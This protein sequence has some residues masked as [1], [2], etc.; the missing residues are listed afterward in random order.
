MARRAYSLDT[1][2]A[3]INA[4]YP[5]R[6]KASDGWLGDAAHQAVASDHNPNAQGVVTA[7]DITH[8][9]QTG[10]DAHALAD[11]LRVNRHPNLKYI[12]S[13]KRIA[14]AFNGWQ[15]QPY[16]GSNPHDKHIHISVGVG[17]DGKSTQPYDDR[18]QWNIK[19]GDMPI[20][21][22]QLDK[23]IKAFKRAEPNAVELSDTN[24][25]NNPGLAIDTMWDV[26]GKANYAQD[27]KPKVQCTAQERQFLDLRKA[28]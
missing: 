27:Q 17:P 8:S 20:S 25:M 16:S 15:W 23:L 12:I 28:I 6:S 3:Q 4:A 21:Q 26:W 18:V 5:N 10:F 19:G 14:G 22:G 9:P 2:V 11:R 13:N 1:L 7:Q 24:W